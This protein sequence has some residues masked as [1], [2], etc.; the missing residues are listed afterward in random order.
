MHHLEAIQRIHAEV[1][2]K[3]NLSKCRIF[4]PQVKYLG[5]LVSHQGVEMVPEYISKIQLWP[6][7]KRG[8]ELISFLGITFYY[9]VFIP[10]YAEVVSPL[11]K[12]VNEKVL[13]LSQNKIARINLLKGLFLSK[14]ISSYPDY[15]S[16]EPFILDTDFSGIAAVQGG[17]ERLIGCFSKS[18]D[19]AQRQYPAHKGELLALI[20]GLRKFEHIL[21]AKKSL[22]RTDTSAITFQRGVK[23]SRGLSA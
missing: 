1:G 4:R 23:E 18:L 21:R 6:F 11:N 13:N 12:Y 22:I 8:K 5:H 9:L 2:M 14:P 20:L 17:K 16:K 15:N 10:K 7:S 3:I 19:S